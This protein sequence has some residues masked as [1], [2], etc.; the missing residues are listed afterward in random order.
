MWSCQRADG[1]EAVGSGR[2]GPLVAWER[3]TGFTAV[4]G[5]WCG[6]AGDGAWT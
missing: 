1:G 2:H 3:W 6:P 5:H 4:H